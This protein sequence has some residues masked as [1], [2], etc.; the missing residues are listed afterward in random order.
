M[1][2]LIIAAL[3]TVFASA[4]AA[5][6]RADDA[7]IDAQRPTVVDIHADGD[8]EGDADLDLGNA[9][10]LED[11]AQ[12]FNP[13]CQAQKAACKAD[14]MDLLGSAKGVCLRACDIEYQECMGL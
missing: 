8:A 5:A 10:P 1:K 3:F 7:S 9:A 4:G 2:K 13:A 11:V 14:C 12:P 6:S